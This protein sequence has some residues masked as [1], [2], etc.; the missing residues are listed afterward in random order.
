MG[1]NIHNIARGLIS[2]II[3]FIDV[4]LYSF[5]WFSI[6]LLLP[7]TP[8]QFKTDKIIYTLN[9]WYEVIH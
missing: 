3:M 5:V 7:L 2:L 8:P 6:T 9:E 4:R 1:Y